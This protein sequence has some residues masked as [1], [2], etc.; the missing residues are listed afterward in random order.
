MPLA[1]CSYSWLKVE[2]CS[3]DC[4]WKLLKQQGHLSAEQ[5]AVSERAQCLAPDLFAGQI[6]V[7]EPNRLEQLKK[8][9]IYLLYAFYQ[10]H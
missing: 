5:K 6:L 7:F 9:Q 2:I 10:V 4:S 3:A 8:P 1:N